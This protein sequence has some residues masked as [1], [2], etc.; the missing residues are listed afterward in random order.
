MSHTVI[1]IFRNKKQA[2]EAVQHLYSVGFNESNVD[3]SVHQSEDSSSQDNSDKVSN[4]F[5]NLFGDNKEESRRHTE[6]GRRGSIVTVHSRSS[7][8]ANLAAKTMDHFGAIDVNESGEGRHRDDSQRRSGAGSETE[9]IPV[10]EE[11]LNVG[12]R[13]VETGGVR[14]KSRIIE[15]PVEETIRLRS[16]HV[17]VERRPV[18]RAATDEELKNFQEGTEEF[19]EK[20]E[21]PVVSKDKRVVEEVN[22]NKEVDERE[23]TIKDKVR[24]TKVDTDEYDENDPRHKNRNRGDSSDRR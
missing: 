17:T 13:E 14:I 22:L 7:E 19:T 8:E 12:K 5:D 18:D 4:F 1:G 6:A 2:R 11:N 21:V 10:I 3:L 23:E 16:E 24:G 15:R 9:S 20:K